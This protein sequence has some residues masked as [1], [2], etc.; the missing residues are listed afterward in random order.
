MPELIDK[1]REVHTP[2]IP[3][4]QI[5]L[6]SARRESPQ[7]KLAEALNSLNEILKFKISHLLMKKRRKLLL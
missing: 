4:S 7:R 6:F 5:I 1:L 2:H 3:A